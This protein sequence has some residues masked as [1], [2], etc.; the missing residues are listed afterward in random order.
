MPVRATWRNLNIGSIWRYRLNVYLVSQ[1]K[2][3]ASLWI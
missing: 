1:F 2:Y 3:I